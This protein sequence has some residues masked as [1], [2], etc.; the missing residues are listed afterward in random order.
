MDNVFFIFLYPQ[1]F[2]H[3]YTVYRIVDKFIP[4]GI[5]FVDNFLKFIAI[6]IFF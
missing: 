3:F 6:A 4:Q 2:F 1:I 5:D